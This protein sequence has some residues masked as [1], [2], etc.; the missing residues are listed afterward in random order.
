MEASH[1]PCIIGI[2]CHRHSFV[3]G[4]EAE[5]LRENLQRL[6]KR[7]VN[8]ILDDV[9]ARD[10]LAFLEA[11]GSR[12]VTPPAPPSPLTQCIN[13]GEG[14]FKQAS[15]EFAEG[16]VG[17]LCKQCF[18]VVKQAFKSA[19][20]NT[21]VTLQT[22]RDE[23]RNIVASINNEVIG[24]QGYFVEPSCITAVQDLKMLANSRHSAMNV[25]RVQVEALTTQLAER[26]HQRDEMRRFAE[27]KSTCAVW[28][29]GGNHPR[30]STMMR[31]VAC[32]CGLDTLLASVEGA[33]TP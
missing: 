2:Y 31:A 13:C 8:A 10:S 4:A 14:L 33:V 32:T 23:A 19:A 15:Y 27:H 20:V 21:H 18:D 17:P 16:E 6:N 7:S 29:F 1:P 25:L 28:P 30:K 3:H 22:E 11:V 9:D 5:E 12:L 26:S 24:S